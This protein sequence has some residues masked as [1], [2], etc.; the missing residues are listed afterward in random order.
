MLSL[1]IILA[2]MAAIVI[3]YRTQFNVGLI[4][5]FFA[6][7][8]GCFVMDLPASALLAKWPLG[9]FFVIFAVALFYNI[10]LINGTL[11]KLALWV[12]YGLRGTPRLLPFALFIA[13]LVVAALGAGFYTVLAFMAPITL[14][15]CDKVKMSHLVGAVAINC[16]ALVGANFM[17]SGSG[18]IFRGL[19]DNAGYGG[20]SFGFSFGIFM[21]TLA[22]ALVLIALFLFLPKSNRSIGQ[23]IELTRPAPFERKQK[24]NLALILLMMLIILLPPLLAFTWP[25]ADTL[26]WLNARVNVGW[27]GLSMAVIGLML[28]LADEKTVIA[29]VPWETLIMICGVGVLVGL[30]IEAGTLDLIAGW[31][32]G[33]IPIIAVPL[34][35]GLV[36]AIMSF[37]SSTLGVVTPA[38]FPLVPALAL[39]TGLNPMLLFVCI[40][41]GA[42]SS[43]ISPF[44]SGGSLILG[45][46]ADAEARARLF[47][48][49]IFVAVPA[50]VAL[51]LLA[52]LLLSLFL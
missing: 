35:I 17:I 9:I 38:L 44:S 11:E 51:S 7:L 5:L 3:G 34:V 46:V 1:L 8:I 41:V 10:A 19:M 49:L 14:L 20:E 39:A 28:G 52:S 31:I 45:A 26:R 48:K 16:G 15:L 4:A 21:A 22:Y 2:L 29:K 23:G 30:A 47:P 18:V 36:A 24:I 33:N 32:G 25:E 27:V 43:A 37:F 6:Y 40:V 12:V 13:A 50:S 42:Q